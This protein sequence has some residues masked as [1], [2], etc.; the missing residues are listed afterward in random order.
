MR[1]THNKR[2][3]ALRYLRFGRGPKSGIAGLISSY[4]SDR[5]GAIGIMFAFMA[6]IVF[7]MVGGALDYGRAVTA[8]H[9]TLAALDAAVLA[10]GRALQIN[11]GDTAAAVAVAN[12]YYQQAKSKGLDIDNTTFTLVGNGTTIQGKTIGKVKSP[13]LGFIGKPEIEINIV[14]K[15]LLAVDGNAGTNIEV[16]LMLD[17]T[18]SMSGSKME[19]LKEAAKDLINIVIWNDQSTYTSRI[20]LVPFSEYVNV[21]QS[22][23]QT[24]TGAAPRSSNDSKTCVKERVSSSYRYTDATPGAGTYFGTYTAG[25][26]CRP[27]SDNVMMPLT[28]DK[29]ALTARIEDLRTEGYTAGH[30]GI[31]WAWMTLAGNWSTVWPS[32][33][34]PGADADLTTYH[35]VKVGDQNLR[36]VKLRK[37]AVLMTDGEFNRKYYGSDSNT[38]AK[39]TCDSMKAKGIEIYSVVFGLTEGSTAHQTMSHCA[40]SPESFYDAQNGADLKAAFRDIALKIATLRLSE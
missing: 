18:G 19:D 28:S 32:G 8:K 21:G 12:R 5:T 22:Y 20:A 35:N 1:G 25:G 9:H 10:A 11:G 26:N 39:A 13:F 30:L 16:A 38:Q 29:S 24:F 33:R 36:V 23:Y 7:G 31:K 3:C 15:A 37:I 34:K 27:R 6:L 17:T 2:Q 4:A 14:S 40:S